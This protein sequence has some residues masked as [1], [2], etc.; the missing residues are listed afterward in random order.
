MENVEVQSGS[1]ARLHC[2][3]P[4]VEFKRDEHPYWRIVGNSRYLLAFSEIAKQWSPSSATVNFLDLL[5]VKDL[6]H[7]KTMQ[8]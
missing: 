2:S 1:R 8:V 3:Q 6:Y 4:M 7:D 5:L